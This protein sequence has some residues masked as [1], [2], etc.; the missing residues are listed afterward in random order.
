M[1]RAV[2]EHATTGKELSGLSG[3]MLADQYA[4]LW[5]ELS[6]FMIFF[7]ILAFAIIATYKKEKGVSLQVHLEHMLF[8]IGAK[9][10]D[11]A[12]QVYTELGGS[13]IISPYV[14]SIVNYLLAIGFIIMTPIRIIHI[15]AT[16]RYH[17][18]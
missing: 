3:I 12:C 7:S 16:K 2:Y 5:I 13:P 18:R 17:G 6:R 15:K 11:H 8:I 14:S 4:D 10:F 1:A 9:V